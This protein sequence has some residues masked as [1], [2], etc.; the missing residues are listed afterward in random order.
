M[1]GA[2]PAYDI[3]PLA[4]AFAFDATPNPQGVNVFFTGISGNGQV[5]VFKKAANGAGDITP[6]ATGSPF[7]A[8]FGLA[9]STDGTKLYVAD[10]GADDI[11]AGTDAGKLFEV[12]VTG[13]A[14]TPVAGSDA[15]LPRG[16]EVYRD[17]QG[18][19]RIVFS[20]VDPADGVPG[21]FELPVAGGTP[22]AIAKGSPFADPGGVAIAATGE[23]YAC[24]TLSR[25][26]KTATVFTIARGVVN[27]LVSGLH[28]GFPCGIALSRDGATLLVAARGAT[29]GTD[30]LAVIDVATQAVTTVTTGLDGLDEPAGMHRAKEVDVFAFADSKAGGTGQIFLVTK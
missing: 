9:T 24:D 1:G 14:V 3:A 12:V 15:V 18:A 16:L 20:G 22:T 6:V 19:D 17:A 26:D 21:V 10:L 28:V 7:V 13:G 5:G 27:E 29:T 2:P 25:A 30:E 23:I 11:T 4:G 8:P